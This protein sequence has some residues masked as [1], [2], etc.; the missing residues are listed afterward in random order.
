MEKQED[1][2]L[3]QQFIVALFIAE[4]KVEILHKT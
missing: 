4:V 2:K 3:I 1:F